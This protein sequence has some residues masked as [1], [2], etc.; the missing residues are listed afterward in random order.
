MFRIYSA[1]VSSVSTVDRRSVFVQLAALNWLFGGETDASRRLYCAV[2]GFRVLEDLYQRV[3]HQREIDQLQ[4]LFVP[5][6]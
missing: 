4:V 5:G 2:T 6:F 1:K 3:T